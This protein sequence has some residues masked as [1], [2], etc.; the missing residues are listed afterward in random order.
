MST[1]VCAVAY[2]G[3]TFSTGTISKTFHKEYINDKGNKVVLHVENTRSP[4]EV[5]D[6]AS[7]EN[8]KGHKITRPIRCGD[9]IDL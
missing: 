8:N 4:S 3:L 2:V 7:E 1:I 6:W 5:D 9:K